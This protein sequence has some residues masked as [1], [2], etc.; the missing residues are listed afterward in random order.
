[1]QLLNG[2]TTFR[3]SFVGQARPAEVVFLHVFRTVPPHPKVV[4]SRLC[5]LL[6]GFAY[7]SSIFEL[8]ILAGCFLVAED[9]VDPIFGQIQHRDKSLLYRQRRHRLSDD[10]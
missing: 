10:L 6:D 3:S 4:S 8:P 5:A 2:M 7:R 9:V 1:M